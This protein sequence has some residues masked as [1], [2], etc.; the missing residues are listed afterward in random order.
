MAV[1]QSD[2]KVLKNRMM[3]EMFKK[4]GKSQGRRNDLVFGMAIQLKQ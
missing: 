4:G 2:C 1:N 3:A